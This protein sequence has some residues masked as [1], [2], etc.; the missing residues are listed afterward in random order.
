MR[1]QDN[2]LGRSS[3]GGL[4]VP[5]FNQ[6]KRN[7]VPL[8]SVPSDTDF[9]SHREYR[10]GTGHDSY[11][12]GIRPAPSHGEYLAQTGPDPYRIGMGPT[13]SQGEC[14]A[15]TGSDPYRFG[16]GSASVPLNHPDCS[17][18][19]NVPGPYGCYESLGPSPPQQYN[20]HRPAPP[21]SNPRAYAPVPH[22]YKGGNI[23]LKSGQSDP[24]LRPQD[25]TLSKR[26]APYDGPGFCPRGPQSSSKPPNSSHQRCTAP[27]PVAPTTSWNFTNSFGPQPTPSEAKTS[28]RTF[29]TVQP[30]PAQTQS[31]QMKPSTSLRILTAT[32]DGMRHWSQF[33]DKVPILFEICATLDSAVTLGSHGAKNFLLRDG[34]EVVQCVY[35][36]NEQ[37]L[38]RLIRGQVHRCVGNYDCGRNVLTCV[39]VRAGHPSELRNA[40]EAVRV[41]DAEMRAVVKAVSE[42]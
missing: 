9:F 15:S 42:V 11:R 39:S 13:L 37:G 14:L 22:P 1:R 34:K 10:S 29:H 2:H 21:G 7:R 41:C 4:S 25:S 26:Q 27:R 6:K 12:A 18:H 17:G 19:L 16:T 5:L 35:Y 40:H 24:P 38:P 33:R 3:T 23:R 31:L 8:T 20:S 30:G 36:E 28:T 32:I